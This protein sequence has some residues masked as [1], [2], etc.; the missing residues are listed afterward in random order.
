M[1]YLF[2]LLAFLFGINTWAQIPD[3]FEGNPKWCLTKSWSVTQGGCIHY[4]NQ[5]HYINGDTTFNNLTY[6]KLYTR[7]VNAGCGPPSAPYNYIES[8]LR[9][10]GEVIY[11]YYPSENAEHILYDFSLSVG[12]TI[13]SGGI[14]AG[15][16]GDQIFPEISGLF[17]VINEIDSI[18]IQG[19]HF[20]KFFFS[21]YSSFGDTIE[22]GPISFSGPDYYIEGIGH[23]FGFIWQYRWFAEWETYSLNAF[24]KNDSIYYGSTLYCD[25]A[26][27]INENS[28]K[29]VSVNIYPNPAKETLHINLLGNITVMTL[30]IFSISGQKLIEKNGPLSSTESI[31]ISQLKSGMYLLEIISVDGF[32]DAKRFVVK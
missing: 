18:L 11:R 31:D 19:E 21:V 4:V 12:D 25:F 27:S 13:P 22:V 20:K 2:L 10:D 30:S 24:S 17:Y 14:V 1:K 6:K 28:I 29:K 7:G 32:R 15:V 3:Y 23:P 9:Q 16:T 26:V 5:V 8:F